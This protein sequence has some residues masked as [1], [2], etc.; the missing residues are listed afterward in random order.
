MILNNINS[1]IEET[2]KNNDKEDLKE[3]E[4]IR[5]DMREA[6]YSHFNSLGFFKWDN[7]NFN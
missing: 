6:W 3:I 7:N 1:L 4:D 5:K 2:I